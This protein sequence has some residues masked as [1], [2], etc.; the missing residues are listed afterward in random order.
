MKDMKRYVENDGQMTYGPIDSVVT[1]K[2][3]TSI[4]QLVN[5]Y[6]MI[7]SVKIFSDLYLFLVP[8]RLL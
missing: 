6:Q 3:Q 8:P 4:P 5:C 2:N 7:V 1:N